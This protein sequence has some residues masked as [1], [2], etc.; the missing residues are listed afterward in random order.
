[1]NNSNIWLNKE[2]INSNI[3]KLLDDLKNKPSTNYNEGLRDGLLLA[4]NCLNIIN[5]KYCKYFRCTSNI[6]LKDKPELG[7]CLKFDKFIYSDDWCK[8]GES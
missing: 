1:M 7:T 2:E 6:A 5:C 3:D 8:D 4:K